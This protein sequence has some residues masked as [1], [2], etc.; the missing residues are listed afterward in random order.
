MYN[1][2]IDD[3]LKQSSSYGCGLRIDNDLFNSFANAD[4]V[5]LWSLSSVDLQTLIDIGFQYSVTWRFTFGI[6]RTNCIIVG[7]IHSMAF[8]FA[9]W[10]SKKLKTKTNCKILGTT[11]S[12]SMSYHSHV[13]KNAAKPEGALCAGYHQLAAATRFFSTEVKVHLWKAIGLPALLYGLENVELW[14][15]DLRELEKLQSSIF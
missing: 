10:V 15:K 12:S 3:L 4:D 13:E 9:H 1:I 11:F 2:F 14:A 8:Q 7:K 6:M 5:N